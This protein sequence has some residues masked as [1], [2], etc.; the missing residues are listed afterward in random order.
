MDKTILL[1][2]IVVVGAF[3]LHNNKS[4]ESNVCP[5]RIKEKIA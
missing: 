2:S 4:I 5:I 1:L 3:I